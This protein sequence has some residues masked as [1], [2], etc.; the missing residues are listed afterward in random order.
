[1]IIYLSISRHIV[2]I[3]YRCIYALIHHLKK[4]KPGNTVGCSNCLSVKNCSKN[5]KKLSSG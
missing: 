3:D 5:N 2:L 4:H 1:M